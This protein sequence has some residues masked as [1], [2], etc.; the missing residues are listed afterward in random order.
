MK[1]RPLRLDYV[2]A[3]PHVDAP[4]RPHLDTLPGCRL[5]ALAEVCR[6][7]GERVRA[8]FALLRLYPDHRALAADPEIDAVAVSAAYALWLQR[9]GGRAVG[10]RV[11]LSAYD[12]TYP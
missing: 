8:R 10:E 1:E 9:S 3:G 5:L 11:S 12:A 7:P 6:D 4:Q 2:V